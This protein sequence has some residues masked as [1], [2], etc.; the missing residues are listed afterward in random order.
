MTIPTL[1]AF[2]TIIFI[3]T[4]LSCILVC[5]QNL[6]HCDLSAKAILLKQKRKNSIPSQFK[7]FLTHL[8]KHYGNKYIYCD[9]CFIYYCYLSLDSIPDQ[10]I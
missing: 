3:D 2:L 6:E 4:V 9:V 1:T 5:S 10:D 8:L 7:H